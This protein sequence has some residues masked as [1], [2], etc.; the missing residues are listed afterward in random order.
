MN[1][2]PVG[3]DISLESLVA[4]LADEFTQRLERGE[5]PAIEDYVQRYPQ[6]A[7]VI[8]NLL[9]SLEFMRLSVPGLSGSDLSSST[10]IGPASP[11]G[12]YRILREVGRGGMG[13][14]YEAEQL[15]LGRRVA[16]KV[17]PFA[18]TMDPRQLQ[19]FKNEAL[20]AAHLDHPHLVDVYGVGCERGVH[21]YA[22]RFIDGHT[23]AEI[24]EQLRELRGQEGASLPDAVVAVQTRLE[25]R[26]PR[27][28]EQTGDY[29]PQ[30]A[31]ARETAVGMGTG[32]SSG[33]ARFSRSYF[34]SVAQ[35]GAQV[36]EA[37]DHAHQMG[38]VHRD[39][40]PSNLMLDVR[41]KVWITDFGLARRDDAARVTVT[42][43]LVGTL[44]Y[45]SPEQALAKRIPID[46]RSDVY[47]LGVSLYEL[48][49]LEPAVGGKDRQEL[50]R[51]IAFEEP[52]PPRRLCREVPAEL[53]T[54]VLKAM[55][56]NPA[57]RYATAAELAEDL[58]HF[59]ADQPIR[60]RRPG[61]VQRLRKWGR[62]HRSL[63][64]AGGIG[65]AL[66]VA[67]LAASTMYAAAA[68]R[69]EKDE[70]EKAQE[71]GE[72]AREAQGK[73]AE[74]RQAAEKERDGAEYR[75]YVANMRLAQQAWEGG[76]IG[77]VKRLL[78][79]L[80][81]REGRRDRRG[82]EWYYLQSLCH[83]DLATFDEGNIGV[84]EDNRFFQSAR[85]L[86]WSTR[87]LLAW[88]GA[89]DGTV[90]VWDSAP[91]RKPFAL[92]DHSSRVAHLAWSPDGR[93]LA[94]LTKFDNSVKVWDTQARQIISTLRP[95][96]HWQVSLR[97][98]AWGPDSRRIAV[99][100]R[101]SGSGDVMVWDSE[102]GKECFTLERVRMANP[103]LV[104]WSPDGTR[105]A[106]TDSHQAYCEVWDVG[107][108]KRAFTI[109]SGAPLQCWSVWSPDGKRLLLP[110]PDGTCI[111]VDSTTG[112]KVLSFG[113][114]DHWVRAVAW[115]PDGKRLA[116]TNRG[117]TTKVWDAGTGKEL[118]SVTHGVDQAD[119]I[120]SL[121]SQRL[122]IASGE[123]IVVWDAPAAKQVLTLRGHTSAIAHLAW[124]PD[125]RQLASADTTLTVKI[126]DTTQPQG[127]R[128]LGRDTVG[129]TSVAWSPDGRRLA[130]LGGSMGPD[131][132]PSIKIWEAG[133]DKAPLT[134]S[135]R[136]GASRYFAWSP[137]GRRLA[138]A[139][140]E[141][142][143]VDAVVHIYD[144]AIGKE[145]LSW[146]AAPPRR[147]T[148][149]VSGGLS[150]DWSPDGKRIASNHCDGT[151]R[152]RDVDT[153]QEVAALSTPATAFLHSVWSPDGQFLATRESEGLI[154][155]WNTTTWRCLG[156]LGRGR[157]TSL[158][159][160]PDGR[161]LAAGS[162][163]SIK[164]WNAATQREV[165]TL[166]S[167][168]DICC[169]VWS[170]DGRRLVSTTGG[171]IRGG[172]LQVWDVATGEE[173][174][175]LPVGDASLLSWNPDG[176]RLAMASGY[177][178]I[179]TILDASSGYAVPRMRPRDQEPFHRNN[180]V[181]DLKTAEQFL[182]KM[183]RRIE[184]EADIRRALSLQEGL[185]QEFPRSHA[186][187]AEL[188]RLCHELGELLEEGGRDAEAEATYRR[189]ATIWK[190]LY[191][192][193]P[194]F[195]YSSRIC[196]AHGHLARVLL[197]NKRL[198]EAVQ[199]CRQA[200]KVAED[201]HRVFREID[202]N[203][204]DMLNHLAWLLA[205]CPEP[206]LAA[207]GEAVALV[208]KAL[209]HFPRAGPYW[210]TLG[211]AHYRGGDWKAAI[212]ALEQ[213]MSLSK[214]GSSFDFLFLAMAHWQLGEKTKAKEWYDKG[215]AWMEAQA[216]ALPA[217]GQQELKRFR[218]EAAE[219]LGV[220]KLLPKPKE[221]APGK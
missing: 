36:A 179:I 147:G 207:P 68:Y 169:I 4:Q 1:E 72:Q 21:F 148:P 194:D 108:R 3:Q 171:D 73:E 26:P 45:M 116:T 211:V 178:G 157:T 106:M 57:D 82:W 172:L 110:T 63:V 114:G 219:L 97:S 88:A 33:S 27:P 156:L 20:A 163:S 134:L 22:M 135:G 56:K 213:S 173:V 138:L 154:L 98:L 19:R 159:W 127:R 146:P 209:E 205:T 217:T 167:G 206:G 42:G 131:W 32:R 196:S 6:H 29:T 64:T 182:R 35:L 76:D 177:E 132:V 58:R 93:R 215:A 24:I 141:R 162:S 216:Q 40:K 41:G 44:R 18:A 52:R 43:D 203:Y 153:G 102:L 174:L 198:A 133:A 129:V 190:Q 128:V 142:P 11:L 204:L 183:N 25:P 85:T 103:G 96:A 55:E 94:S 145:L 17:L 65:L 218:A 74:Q 49:T 10:D 149:R 187:R 165:L 137:D 166:E 92:R 60:A 113:G 199:E 201:H 193:V 139:E 86:A 67:A 109:K 101:F 220:R 37:L 66:V 104:T 164:I 212:A 115:S 202:T 112:A 150:L 89:D 54:I 13:I 38:V 7:G 130:S 125:G 186:Y 185:V 210:N 15:S 80:R 144:P 158:A 191:S 107:T 61:V 188:A 91:G 176:Q 28:D 46:H 5:R 23:L 136:K 124:S 53:E 90:W 143:D 208:K 69:A 184:A 120:W 14:V 81:P 192:D 75:L 48:L 2:V 59:L 221:P 151:V 70:R 87:G 126:W 8:R 100:R 9:S 200:I 30:P 195:S 123:M 189:T 175:R 168:R 170:P 78:E 47:S 121:D 39:I 12:D 160:S 77:N 180:L 105:V 117:S 50:L 95:G 62:R 99:A 140:Q 34:R 118:F 197:R 214:G 79:A 155:L 161:M 51:Q 152:I 31:E 16:L 111:L 181:K 84:P 122:A 83:T 119:P 71:A